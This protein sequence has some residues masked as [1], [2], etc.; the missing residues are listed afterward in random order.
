METPPLEQMR[1]IVQS[2]IRDYAQYE[3]SI[4]DIDTEVISVPEQDHYALIHVGFIK[5]RRV[6]GM[7]I[8]ID[9]IDGKIWIQH[10][11]TSPGVAL[12]LVEAGI[13]HEAIVLGWL[14]P[15]VRPHTDF[16]A[17]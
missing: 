17:G 16:A 4:G 3:P 8:H 1:E 13:P 6:H 5:N 12:D 2:I 14:P 11:G 7:V 10:D 15:S 9:I